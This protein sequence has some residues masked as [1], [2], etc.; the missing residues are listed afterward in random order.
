MEAMSCQACQDQVYL[1]KVQF[2]D[3]AAFF[4]AQTAVA[5]WSICADRGTDLDSFHAVFMP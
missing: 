3:V 4:T 2:Y 1:D 5:A